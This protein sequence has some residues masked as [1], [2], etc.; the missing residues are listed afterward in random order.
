[1][2]SVSRDRAKSTF[3]RHCWQHIDVCR[4]L[5]QSLYFDFNKTFESRILQRMKTVWMGTKKQI[6]FSLHYETRYK[7]KQ[8]L[9]YLCFGSFLTR[10]PLR[11]LHAERPSSWLCEWV[12]VYMMKMMNYQAALRKKQQNISELWS[13]LMTV[14]CWHDQMIYSCDTWPYTAVLFVGIDFSF[15]ELRMLFRWQI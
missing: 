1:M 14:Q 9:Q 11:D 6:R 12:T 3:Q 2:L 5:K 10:V 8:G 4:F 7:L 15:S 13:I